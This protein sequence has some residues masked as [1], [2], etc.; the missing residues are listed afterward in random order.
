[1]RKVV[2][3][4]G[5]IGAGKDF[6]ADYLVNMK[7][8]YKFSFADSLKDFTS[9][10]YSFPKAFC[11]THEGKEMP[12]TFENG[13]IVTIRDLLILE[14]AEQRKINENVWIDYIIERILKETP[15][16]A[17]IVISDFRFPNEYYEM[18][19]RFEGTVSARIYRDSIVP[20]NLESEHLLDEFIFDLPILNNG[21][22]E[23]LYYSLQYLYDL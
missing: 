8:Y 19:K 2:L 14:G 13:D 3:L 16:D 15:E 17:K 6:I 11:Y 18:K 20:A 22:K 12:Y 1:M 21:T 10:K 4:S 9:K 23:E 5:Y 7:G